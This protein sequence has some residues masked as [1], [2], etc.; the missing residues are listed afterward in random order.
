MQR[1]V[2]SSGYIS[3]ANIYCIINAQKNGNNNDKLG[4]RQRELS[5]KYRRLKSSKAIL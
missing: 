5:Q 1:V 4:E 2:V 3:S